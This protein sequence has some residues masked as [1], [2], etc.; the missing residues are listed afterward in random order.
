[1][2]SLLSRRASG[3]DLGAFCVCSRCFRGTPRTH[4][5]DPTLNGKDRRIIGFWIDAGQFD[6]DVSLRCFVSYFQ[7]FANKID[8][9][10]ENTQITDVKKLNSDT[11]LNLLSSCGLKVTKLAEQFIGS[12]DHEVIRKLHGIPEF[13][14]WF[15]RGAPW[16]T[17]ESVAIGMVFVVGKRSN[18]RDFLDAWNQGPC[19]MFSIRSISR[20]CI[21]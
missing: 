4:G 10:M 9:D 2:S 11:E 12:L 18:Q 15:S 20:T 7:E 17:L 6:D 16:K 21:P 3:A 5:I 14:L 8:S 13:D 1:M 19:P